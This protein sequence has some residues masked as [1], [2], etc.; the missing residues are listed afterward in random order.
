MQT[1]DYRIHICN[2]ISI[3]QKIVLN[4][5]EH[6]NT[7]EFSTEVVSCDLR[8]E[9]CSF[10]CLRYWYIICIT[11]NNSPSDILTFLSSVRCSYIGRI[12]NKRTPEYRPHEKRFKNERTSTRNWFK[13]STWHLLTSLP[14]LTTAICNQSSC[15]GSERPLWYYAREHDP[16]NYGHATRIWKKSTNQ[17]KRNAPSIFERTSSAKFEP[18]STLWQ[19]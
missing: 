1:F 3:P 6:A 14:S 16:R 18:S 2:W 10:C 7:Y 8:P 11:R 9:K 19:W 13:E 12:F 4:I 17:R 5:P 15:S